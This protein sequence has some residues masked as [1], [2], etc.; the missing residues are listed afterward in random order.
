MSATRACGQQGRSFR[1]HLQFFFF[2]F[3]EWEMSTWRSEKRFCRSR[4]AELFLYLYENSV[5]LDRWA[6]TARALAR[7]RL[8]LTAR[9][10]DHLPWLD[11]DSLARQRHCARIEEAGGGA[12]VLSFTEWHLEI[13]LRDL[14]PQETHSPSAHLFL[15]EAWETQVSHAAKNVNPFKWHHFWLRSLLDQ[16]FLADPKRPLRVSEHTHVGYDN[17][18][19]CKKF[20]LAVVRKKKSCWLSRGSSLLHRAFVLK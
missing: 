9:T 11:T 7:G 13:A 10:T 17:T 8:D 15:Y 4:A 3:L 2:A 19:P 12:W 5:P 20:L 1:S 6:G 16:P 18:R 14:W